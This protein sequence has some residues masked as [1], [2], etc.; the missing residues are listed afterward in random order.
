MR[1]RAGVLIG[2]MLALGVAVAIPVATAQDLPDIGISADVRATP[3]KA[4]TKRNPRGLAVR[5]KAKVTTESGFERPIVTGLDL[6]IGRGLI[7]NFDDAATCTKRQLD[8][9]GPSA[10]PKHSIIGRAKGTAYADTV[11]TH[12]D[13]VL[14]NGGPKRHLA[15]VT[16]YHPSLVK[17]TIVVKV[18]KLRG[19][20]WMQR[21][22]LTVPERLRI[23]AGVP[24]Q[25]TAVDM[26]VGGM[27]YAEEYIASTSCPRGGWKYKATAHFLFDL[28][29]QKTSRTIDGSIPCRK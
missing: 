29:D 16:L 20:K 3:D 12:P 19:G 25:V 21:E 23:V 24:I 10:C 13:I 9:A 6:W 18:T 26:T 8:R 7:W 17:E 22:S 2:A 5:A 15:Y 27:P 1:R 4:G 14:L 11:V 28:T